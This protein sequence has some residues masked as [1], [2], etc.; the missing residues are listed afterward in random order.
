MAVLCTTHHTIN[1]DFAMH[2]SINNFNDI[3]TN[4]TLILFTDI[5]KFTHLIILFSVMFMFSIKSTQKTRLEL[6]FSENEIYTFFG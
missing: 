2:L 4:M 5:L 1:V 6:Y 3:Y